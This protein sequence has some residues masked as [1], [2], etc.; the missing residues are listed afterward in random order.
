MPRID[1]LGFVLCLALGSV[2]T[3]SAQDLFCT[4][5]T[6]ETTGSS[7]VMM[8]NAPWTTSNDLYTI[9][10]D[11]VARRSGNTIFVVNRFL[12]DIGCPDPGLFQ[13]HRYGNGD[14][15]ASCPDLYHIQFIPVFQHLFE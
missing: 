11:A 3:T 5:T 8:L 15:S 13:S 14:I 12:A 7:S 2:A 4:T 10:S 1:F 9:H 6:F